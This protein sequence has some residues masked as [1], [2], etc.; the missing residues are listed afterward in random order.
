MKLLMYLLKQQYQSIQ[1]PLRQIILIKD[2]YNTLT[3]VFE[4]S[5]IL[6]LTVSRLLKFDPEKIK[7][8]RINQNLSIVNWHFFRYK[9]IFSE[10][11]K[12]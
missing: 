12:E 5:C 3:K 7:K 2:Y 6:K 4:R 10:F 11:T 9:N 8:N 1:L